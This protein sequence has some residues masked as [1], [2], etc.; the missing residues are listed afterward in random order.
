MTDQPDPLEFPKYTFGVDVPVLPVMKLARARHHQA[1]LSS[2]LAVWQAGRPIVADLSV[3]GHD[4]SAIVGRLRVRQP[5]LTNQWSL[6]F[7]DAVHNCRSA[8]DAA[9]WAFA[10]MGGVVPP[11]PRQVQF[12]IFDDPV[13]WDRFAADNLSTVPSPVLLRTRMLQP[14]EQ[15][16]PQTISG[17]SLLQ[18]FSNADKHRALGVPRPISLQLNL[19]ANIKFVDEA[20]AEGFGTAPVELIPD[21]SSGL[22]DGSHVLTLRT[23]SEVEYCSGELEILVEPH[24]EIRPGTVIPMTTALESAIRTVEGTLRVISGGILRQ[25]D[26]RADRA[27][28]PLKLQPLSGPAM[29]EWRSA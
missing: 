19:A 13:R 5:P 4:R 21:F 11:K 12:P 16:D 2:Q 18:E 27:W 3:S 20:A 9:M 6:V 1:E 8:L 25:D 7:G 15:T 24:L 28:S 17:L 29:D 14:F 22:A 23:G 10:S 26:P